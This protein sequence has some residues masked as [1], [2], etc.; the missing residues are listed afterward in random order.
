[1]VGNC[2]GILYRASVREA[3]SAVSIS[4]NL[5]CARNPKPLGEQNVLVN[6][7]HNNATARF[8]IRKSTVKNCSRTTTR[9]HCFALV[10]S[11]RSG[12]TSILW[13]MLLQ[14]TFYVCTYAAVTSF[15]G[16]TRRYPSITK[17]HA[18]VLNQEPVHVDQ[19]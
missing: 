7:S 19:P 5:D 13:N 17:M 11:L 10:R 1:M 14:I 2:P 6:I 18:L 12:G 9:A 8:R 15:Q 4:V 16:S 3:S